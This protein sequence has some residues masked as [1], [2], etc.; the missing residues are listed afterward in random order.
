MEQR[1]T[2]QQALF[3]GLVYNTEGELAEVVWIGG[4]AHYAIPDD[5]MRLHVT[6]ATIDDAVL[7]HLKEQI[8]AHQDEII[9]GVLNMIGKDDLFSK[10]AVESSIRNMEQNV[11][12][13]NPAQWLP[14]LRMM[15]LRVV[16]DHHGEITELIYPEHPAGDDDRGDDE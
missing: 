9:R 3:S 8:T 13:S 7:A 5:G 11:R 6:A 2:H 16:V 12:Q 1:D 4:E 10:A 14:W 15:G